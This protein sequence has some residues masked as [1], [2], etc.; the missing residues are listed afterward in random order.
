[1]GIGYLSNQAILLGSTDALK[2]HAI[3]MLVLIGKYYIWRCRGTGNTPS[4]SGFAK[5]ALEYLAVEKYIARTT[6]SVQQFD[7]RWQKRIEKLKNSEQ[8]P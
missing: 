5:Q 4:M 7:L 1:M 3:Y 6:D 2:C 8:P